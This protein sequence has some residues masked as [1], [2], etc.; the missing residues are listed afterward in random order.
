MTSRKGAFSPPHLPPPLPTS[1]ASDTAS[2]HPPPP[3]PSSQS[4]AHAQYAPNPYFDHPAI[5]AHSIT[6]SHNL[7]HPQEPL[8]SHYAVDR[9]AGDD[10]PEG[11]GHVKKANEPAKASSSPESSSPPPKRRA[12]LSESEMAVGDH[13]SVHLK[14]NWSPGFKEGG[15]ALLPHHHHHQQQQNSLSSHPYLTT[16]PSKQPTRYPNEEDPGDGRWQKVSDTRQPPNNPTLHHHSQSHQPSYHQPSYHQSSY[17]QSSSH[18]PSSHHQQPSSPRSSSSSTATTSAAATTA[19][20]SISPAFPTA[21]DDGNTLHAYS[22]H[23]GQALPLW[24]H[25]EGHQQGHQVSHHPSY[26]SS[27]HYH[28]SSHHHHH[29]YSNHPLNPPYHPYHSYHP[30]H[31]Y[32]PYHPIHPIHPHHPYPSSPHASP[33]FHPYA[34]P[35]SAPTPLYSIPSEEGSTGPLISPGASPGAGGVGGVHQSSL[36]QPP[37]HSSSA[38]SLSFTHHHHQ[39]YFDHTLPHLGAATPQEGFHL[40]ASSPPFYPPPKLPLPYGLPSPTTLHHSSPP[41]LQNPSTPHHAP[42]EDEHFATSPPT[43]PAPLLPSHPPTRQHQQYQNYHEGSNSAW[44]STEER[45]TGFID[46]SLLPPSLPSHLAS[47]PHPYTRPSYSHTHFNHPYHPPAAYPSTAPGTHFDHSTISPITNA[48]SST[49]TTFQTPTAES[50]PSEPSEHPP[51]ASSRRRPK[52][53]GKEEEEEIETP[54]PAALPIPS[55]KS[56][57][58]LKEPTLREK[59]RVTPSLRRSSTLKLAASADPL[60]RIAAQ[61]PPSFNKIQLPPT[62]L[63][64]IPFILAQYAP[65]RTP[66]KEVPSPPA[67]KGKSKRSS[68]KT[69]PHAPNSANRTGEEKATQDGVDASSSP[70]DPPQSPKFHPLIIHIMRKGIPKEKAAS[71]GDEAAERAMKSG[72]PESTA[73]EANP[74]LEGE[75][76]DVQQVQ[77]V[78]WVVNNMGSRKLGKKVLPS[79]GAKKSS[80]APQPTEKKRRGKKAKKSGA[81][82]GGDKAMASGQEKANAVSPPA[83]KVT[84][85]SIPSLPTAPPSHTDDS[86][87]SSS[88]TSSS[89]SSASSSSS[90]PQSSPS[91]QEGVE[92]GDDSGIHLNSANLP[93]MPPSAPQGNK[94]KKE[95]TDSTPSS[96]SAS[97]YKYLWTT[98]LRSKEDPL[99]S[100]PLALV[101]TSSPFPLPLPP[102]DGGLVDA[103]VYHERV[104]ADF[105]SVGKTIQFGLI[106]ASSRLLLALSA[107]QAWMRNLTESQLKNIQLDSLLYCTATDKDEHRA[108][109]LRRLSS[110]PG[111]SPSSIPAQQH[112][113]LPSALLFKTESVQQ[114]LFIQFSNAPALPPSGTTSAAYL[115]SIDD[116]L[117]TQQ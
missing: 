23:Q 114:G 76:R 61:S 9:I 109:I 113:M 88:L 1:H 47:N 112:H 49:G 4:S 18:Q 51:R 48:S 44:T 21:L 17:H 31:P 79:T 26:G 98:A 32:H 40:H 3:L 15:F 80:E 93:T 97:T 105:P 115:N 19:A 55:P 54:S 101:F 13:D 16:V 56:S 86:S 67:P 81:S 6:P 34:S 103:C 107:P 100:R 10:L 82:L 12:P 66:T 59:E 14:A 43:L 85:S 73:T 25:Q 37:T 41:G 106:D 38:P 90:T 95:K 63:S 102:R 42:Q 46:S 116:Q 11:E 92:G 2:F 30:H 71:K 69:T 75:R 58:A 28:P 99:S 20:S 91:T 57:T 62:H 87:R 89:S 68:K 24:A 72:V 110:R 64:G 60:P 27:Q 111:L 33:R 50:I 7:P 74:S 8:S 83:K 77:L 108:L 70:T 104:I 36:Y 52:R 35:Q 78:A 29:H 22:P 96:V 39:G 5:E 84:P 65:E 94:K 53:K 45:N 117:G